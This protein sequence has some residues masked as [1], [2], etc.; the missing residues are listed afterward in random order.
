MT[1]VYEQPYVA[2]P[3][4]PPKQEQMEATTEVLEVAPGILRLQLPTNFTG[5]GHV[6]TYAIEDGR[7]FTL[8]DPGLPGADSWSALVDRLGRAAI[9][10]ERV[11]TVLV[12]H[13]H[14]DHFG[15]AN[16]LVEAAGADVL[17]ST[18]FRK[19]ADLIELDE[20]PL[21][22][23]EAP[24][25][26]DPTT[27][28][29]AATQIAIEEARGGT[30]VLDAGADTDLAVPRAAARVM[31]RR[32][33]E[34]IAG[35]Q[36]DEAEMRTLPR[37]TITV[38]DAQPVRIGD[39]EWIAV[40]TPGHTHDHLCI[41]SPEDGVLLSGDHVLPTITP[42]VGGLLGN[43]L[44]AQYLANLEKVAGLT[45]VTTVLPAHGQPFTDLPGRCRAIQEHH[46]KRLGQLRAAAPTI[47]WGPIALWSEQ[48]FAARS[49]GHMAD[50]ETYA[51][52]EHLRLAGEAERRVRDAQLEYRIHT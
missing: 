11:H 51:H 52:L 32:L 2:D 36:V 46:A 31:R 19:W 24:G 6:N 17:T 1:G 39:R 47:G 15:G 28:V 23:L 37:P 5:L 48:L 22:D 8:V 21:D 9:P 27:L 38:V 18:T 45:G 25:V 43:D 35:G 40:L 34:A 41:W 42:H 13:S 44:L 20:S 4:R 7:G 30:Q 29:E 14:A 12:T 3:A 50:S 26:P 49:L 33:R 10:V 16:R